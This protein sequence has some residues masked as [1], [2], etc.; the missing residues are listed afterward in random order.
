MKARDYVFEITMGR[1]TA[2]EIFVRFLYD[3]YA[4]PFYGYT[5]G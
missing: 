1:P 3:V 4:L 2:L 5:H